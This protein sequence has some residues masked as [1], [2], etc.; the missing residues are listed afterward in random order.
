MTGDSV[1]GDDARS[2]RSWPSCRRMAGRGT[3]RAMA[4][5]VHGGMTG[6]G[7]PWPSPWSLTGRRWLLR[8]RRVSDP[9]DVKA[10]VVFAHQVTPPEELVRVA[11]RDD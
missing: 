8:R 3:G 6:A 11:P 4:R 2:K 9:K 5:Q 10:Y 7:C 1:D